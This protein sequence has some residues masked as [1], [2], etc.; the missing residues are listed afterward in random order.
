VA[1]YVALAFLW[2]LK[3]H[4]QLSQ[5]GALLGA[6]AL[7]VALQG[8]LATASSGWQPGRWAGLAVGLV[9]FASLRLLRRQRWPRY[10]VQGFALTGVA[11]TAGALLGYV[12]PASIAVAALAV[13]AGMLLRSESSRQ[14]WQNLGFMTFPNP[15]FAWAFTVGAALV[16]PY[17]LAVPVLLKVRPRPV[18]SSDELTPCQATLL[19]RLP[20]EVANAALELLP[21]TLQQRWFRPD[22]MRLHLR[23]PLLE[24]QNAPT[25]FAALAEFLARQYGVRG[26]DSE[27]KLAEFCRMYPYTAL[28]AALQLPDVPAGHAPPG[29]TSNHLGAKPGKL[30]QLRQLVLLQRIVRSVGRP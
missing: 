30:V 12:T 19:L 7:F 1:I 17:G 27:E 21:I 16:S 20:L 9:A 22:P 5:G 15:W 6:A 13:V 23:E 11:A 18:A 24:L 25:F 2:A 8:E 29:W 4:R 26:L 28:E 14:Q 10:P 3:F